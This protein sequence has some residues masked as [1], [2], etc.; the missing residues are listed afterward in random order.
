M[1]INNNLQQSAIGYKVSWNLVHL[2]W[3][4]IRQKIF[5]TDR[6]FLKIM[7]S[8]S[9]HL[10]TCKSTKNRQSQI[11]TEV[12]MFFYLYRRKCKRAKNRVCMVGK[13]ESRIFLALP[14]L[15]YIWTACFRKSSISICITWSVPTH[16]T[17]SFNCVW[18]WGNW[19]MRNL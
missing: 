17:D 7:K 9:E 8:Y 10:K 15:L 19:F 5:D 16:P 13:W 4:Y 2:F 18:R 11:L 6:N 1:L 3:G 12:F 14:R